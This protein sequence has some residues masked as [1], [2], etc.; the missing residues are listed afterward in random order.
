MSKPN[1]QEGRK[2]ELV[3][4]VEVAANTDSCS[5]L[6]GCFVWLRKSAGPFK[7]RKP[8]KGVRAKDLGVSVQKYNFYFENGLSGCVPLSS[9][10]DVLPSFSA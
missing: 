8:L 1:Y 10:L 6:K 4:R 3:A 2:G 5:R 9:T 7:R